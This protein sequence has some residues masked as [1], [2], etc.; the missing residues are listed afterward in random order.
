[1]KK[2]MLLVYAGL[3]LFA[4]VSAY[5]ANSATQ[6]VTYEVSAINEI[7]V[8][9]NP[10]ALTVSTATAG[11][12]P[13]SVSDSS[14]TYAITTNGTSM[15]ITGAI[16]TNMPANT[17][18]SVNLTAPTGGTSAG[19][20]SLSTV[21]ADLVTGIT[22]LAESGKTIAYTLS[23]TVTAGVVGS[24]SKTVTLTIAAGA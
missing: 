3:M 4:A 1:M 9:G 15:K 11:S 23:A 21:A 19:A 7:S 12:Q 2:L 14:T 5:A 24:A 20:T 13:N 18:L 8:S 10:G 6:T 16:N 22:T 17:T